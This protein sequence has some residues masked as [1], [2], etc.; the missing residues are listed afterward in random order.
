MYDCRSWTVSAADDVP[1]VK[2]QS[3]KDDDDDDAVGDEEDATW[4]VCHMFFADEKLKVA[5][6]AATAI[7]ATCNT[8]IMLQYK[9]V[10]A[11]SRSLPASTRRSWWQQ[12]L[13]F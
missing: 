9:Y 3:L 13:E 5:A 1:G 12:M 7:R 11:F 4:K 10:V 6:T 8:N 2:Q